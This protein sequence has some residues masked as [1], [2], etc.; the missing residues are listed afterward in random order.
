MKR[1]YL[2]LD[3]KPKK[4]ELENL[5]KTYGDIELVEPS[6]AARDFWADINGYMGISCR[7]FCRKVRKIIED[8]KRKE[9]N[10]AWIEGD[11]FVRRV[12]SEELKTLD[13]LVI[14][15]I[16]EAEYEK[17]EKEDGTTEDRFKCF[18]HVKFLEIRYV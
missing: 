11:S 14:C 9:T 16:E 15:S 5:N 18:K 12:L 10:I 17:I 4:D 7:E 1:V 13:I 2:L 3:R 6:F 8:I